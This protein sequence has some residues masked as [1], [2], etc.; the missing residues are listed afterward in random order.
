[1]RPSLKGAAQE[2]VAEQLVRDL[3]K[4]GHHGEL[5]LKTDQEPAIRA[6]F[7][8]A[9]RSASRQVQQIVPEASSVGESQSNGLVEQAV[10][11]LE[12]QIRCLKLK[13]EDSLGCLSNCSSPT[14]AWIVDDSAMLLTYWAPES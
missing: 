10:Q 5:T 1:M 2:W 3:L 6:L 9:V 12:K 11:E 14:M 13:L 4:F 8:S 7:E